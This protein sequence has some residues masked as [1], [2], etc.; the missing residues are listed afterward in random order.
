MAVDRMINET[1]GNDIIDK[2]SD[3][4]DNLED[5]SA[6]TPAKFG[7]GLAVCNTAADT[8]A[9]TATL[10]NY[11]LTEGAPVSVTFTY[12]NTASNATLNLNGTG[13]KPI[14]YKG[15]AIGNDIIVAGDTATFIYDGTNYKITNI[16]TLAGPGSGTVKSVAASDGLKTDLTGNDPIQNT[17]TVKLNLKSTTKHANSVGN[18]ED[19]NQIY[20]VQLDKD[21]VPCV[22]VP[23]TDEGVKQTEANTDASYELLFAKSSGTSEKTEGVSKSAKATMNPSTGAFTVNGEISGTGFTGD[24]VKTEFAAQVANLSDKKVPSEKLVKTSLDEKVAG[25]A[26]STQNDIATYNDATGKEVKDSGV[27]IVNYT[28]GADTSKDDEV[29]TSKAVNKMITDKGY[30][31]GPSS[32][33]GDT[34]ALFDSTTGKLVKSSSKTFDTNSIS[35]DTSK[36]PNSKL[37]KDALDGKVPTT[38]TINGKG[39]DNNVTLSGDDIKLTSYTKTTSKADL[40]ATDK[41]NQAFDKLE[42]RVVANQTNILSAESMVCDNAFSTSTAYAEGDIVTYN[43]KLYKFKTAHSAGAWNSSEVDQISTTGL[44]TPELIELCDSG[45]KNLLSLS[46]AVSSGSTYNKIEPIPAGR[47]II[48][49]KFS[50][51]A[52]GAIA[53]NFYNSSGSEVGLYEGTAPS[54]TNGVIVTLTGAATQV[55]FWTQV[56]DITISDWMICSLAA[57]NVSHKYV[58]YRPNWDLVGSATNIVENSLKPWPIL[59]SGDNLD[60]IVSAM[61]S[62]GLYFMFAVGTVDV[63]NKPANGIFAVRTTSYG[64]GS[65]VQEVTILTGNDRGKSYVR[66]FIDSNNWSSWIQTTN[67]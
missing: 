65:A 23:W 1:Q 44:I 22:G 11:V 67:V 47:Y 46:S 53:F 37:V 64:G 15:S 3:I 13:A 8:A 24:G 51:T 12:A 50:N 42:N 45:A 43:H 14:F 34:I 30:V 33:T 66:T 18:P 19:T 29:P 36:V 59:K 9:K 26:S 21:G 38:R 32:V 62:R 60:N 28:T 2:L 48:S 41:V 52:A 35:D 39:L 56:N 49:G 6:I 16:D 10:A 17:G 5:V 4:A 58:P 57:W 63:L 54:V 31:V 55:K 40:A 25:P 20:P 61:E 27:H 7:L